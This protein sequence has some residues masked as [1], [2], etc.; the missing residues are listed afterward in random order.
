MIRFEDVWERRGF[1]RVLS[2]TFPPHSPVRIY[3][4]QRLRLP[5]GSDDTPPS[6]APSRLSLAIWASLGDTLA[7]VQGKKQQNTLKKNH[8]IIR[9]SPLVV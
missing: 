9:E 5:R 8:D 1:S 4:V 3:P 2:A 6:R 7:L